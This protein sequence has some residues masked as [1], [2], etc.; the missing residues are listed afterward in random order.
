MNYEKMILD[1]I[2][3]LVSN[4]E[5]INITSNTDS[6]KNITIFVTGPSSEIGKLIGMKGSVANDIRE[7]VRIGAKIESKHVFVKF[8]EK[9]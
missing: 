9:V 3:P 7:V 4:I 6:K 2:T 1:I 5:D 8:D